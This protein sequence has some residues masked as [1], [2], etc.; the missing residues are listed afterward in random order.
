MNTQDRD[1]LSLDHVRISEDIQ[2]AGE[3]FGLCN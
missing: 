1:I 2:V 3:E